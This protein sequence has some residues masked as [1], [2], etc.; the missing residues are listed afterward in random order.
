[1]L[2]KQTRTDI[3][4]L[5]REGN[6]LRRISRFL[7][8]SRNSVRKVVRVGSD[9]P[10]VIH[11][12]RKLDPHR[13]R[14]T[15]ML[16][17]FEGNIVKVHRALAEAATSAQY[18]TLTAFCRKNHLLDGVCRPPCSVLA[19]RQWLL[20]LINGPHTVERLQ[21]QLP[22]ATDLR[23]LFSH[24]KHGRSR[25]RKKASTILARNLGISNSLIAA[26]LRS[27]RKTTRRYYKMYLEAG[28]EKLFGF[29]S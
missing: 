11:R 4:L 17:E 21:S 14:I 8:V 15:Q 23:I 20:D 16:M 29:L 7:S 27:S 1:M 12:P 6:G 25:H 19:A 3:L 13:E 24:L 28:P 22:H 26:A 18:S 5:R 10:P 9:E 2:D